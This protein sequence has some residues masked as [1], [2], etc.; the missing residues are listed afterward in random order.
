MRGNPADIDLN[1]DGDMLDPG[2][3][4][5]NGNG[6]VNL[7]E[8]SWICEYNVRPLRAIRITVRFEHPTSKQMKQVTVVHSLRDT[9]SV[10]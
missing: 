7:A 1:S 4:D 6:I 8:P 3:M 10:P 2:E 9:T 5:F